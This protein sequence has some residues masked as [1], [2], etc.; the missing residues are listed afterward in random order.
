MQAEK[1]KRKR[2]AIGEK[3]VR[4]EADSDSDEE[5]QAEAIGGRWSRTDPGLLG[6]NTPAFLKPVLS[7]ADSDKLADL[8]SAYDY[9]KLFQS[10]SFVTEIVYQSKLYAVQKGYEKCMDH[11]SSDTYR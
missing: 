9:Y 1:R 6:S 4:L 5:Q 7:A 3:A 11:I 8:N 2:A 10:D